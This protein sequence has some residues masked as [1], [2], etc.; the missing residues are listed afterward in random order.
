[1]VNVDHFVLC[2]SGG[3]SRFQNVAVRFNWQI[4]VARQAVALD[5]A[6]AAG[7]S[8]GLMLLDGVSRGGESPYYAN[9][10]ILQDFQAGYDVSRHPAIIINA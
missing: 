7:A 8:G 2:R 9:E 3:K 1:M 4:P 10:L 5:K 6:A